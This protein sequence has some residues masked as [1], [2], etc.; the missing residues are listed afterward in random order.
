MKSKPQR[1]S[2]LTLKEAAHLWA[3]AKERNWVL[4]ILFGVSNGQRYFLYLP[5][6]ITCFS[7]DNDSLIYFF[8]GSP[9]ILHRCHSRSPR[10][11]LS[12]PEPESDPES[13][14]YNPE[15]EPES[16]PW[17]PTNEYDAYAS[18]YFNN[19]SD[20]KN[21]LWCKCVYM[22]LN[23]IVNNSSVFL[24]KVLQCFRMACFILRQVLEVACFVS[25]FP[26]P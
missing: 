22:E 9:R 25:A 14:Q 3:T 12:E 7:A 20:Y 10:A 5:V 19:K 8:V 1:L 21:C 11:R 13:E 24:Y 15:S 4:N 16:K 6:S 17:G 23:Y 26:I 18:P 2:R